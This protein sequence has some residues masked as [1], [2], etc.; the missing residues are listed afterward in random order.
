MLLESQYR[1][2][3]AENP[4]HYLTYD[5]WFS[6]WGE[7]N[8]LPI[9]SDD[10]QIGPNGAYERVGN[11]LDLDYQDNFQTSLASPSITVGRPFIIA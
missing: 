5:E 2:W 10:F 1:Q 11:D 4:G 9:V 3:L 7:I 6:K 8:N